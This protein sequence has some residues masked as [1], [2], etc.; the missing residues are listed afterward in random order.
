VLIHPTGFT[1]PQR[2]GRF[3]FNNVIGNPL[4]TTVA[5]HYQIFDG[6]F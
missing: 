1:Q 3:Y 2:F 4:D 6:V 5:L